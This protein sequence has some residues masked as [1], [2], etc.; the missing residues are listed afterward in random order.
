LLAREPSRESS[1]GA[2]G[3]FGLRVWKYIRERSPSDIR[4]NL[5]MG[6]RV[7]SIPFHSIK[8]EMGVEKNNRPNRLLDVEQAAYIL[9]CYPD[10]VMDLV[11][12][13]RLKA[14]KQGK[15]FKFR[16]SDVEACKK[17]QS[18]FLHRIIQRLKLGST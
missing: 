8:K 3:D 1:K 4:I 7:D 6:V 10:G 17:E 16:L 18:T 9:D 5:C 13:G 2:T 15:F 11:H 14:I 12:S